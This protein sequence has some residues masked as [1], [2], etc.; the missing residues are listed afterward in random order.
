MATTISTG[1]TTELI[2]PTFDEWYMEKHGQSFE[3]DQRPDWPIKHII[4]RLTQAMG[5]YVT[6]VARMGK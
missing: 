2:I 3:D 4:G 1:F 6:Y 5:E